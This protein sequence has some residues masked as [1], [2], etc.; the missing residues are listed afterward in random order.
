MYLFV[1][2]CVCVFVCVCVCAC[3]CVRKREGGMIE[4]ILASKIVSY[5]VHL[6]IF[7][8]VLERVGER[9]RERECVCVCM[10]VCKRVK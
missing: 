3:A 7:I 9:E 1:C 8:E 10:C 4:C 5:L 2:V 6:F